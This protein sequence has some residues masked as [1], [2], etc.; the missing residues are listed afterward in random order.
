MS[1]K[2]FI[3]YKFLPV[4]VAFLLNTVACIES[5]PEGTDPVIPEEEMEEQ[6]P[7]GIDVTS[8]LS[9]SNARLVRGTIPEPAML[10]DF[11]IDKDTLYLNANHTDR[12]HLRTS[13]C[14]EEDIASLLIWVV[15]SEEYVTVT[16]ETFIRSSVNDSLFLT[17]RQSRLTE[18]PS[19]PQT[20]LAFEW[21]L[22]CGE[23]Q[24]P[25]YVDI[26]ILPVTTAGV[27]VD[28]IK[29]R[30]MIPDANTV[31][32][33]TPGPDDTWVW[34]WTTVNGEFDSSPGISEIYTFSLNGCCRDGRSVNCLSSFI[35][36]SEWI[37]LDYEHFST[38]D[39]EYLTFKAD[40]TMNGLLS[41]TI[42]NIDPG[43]SDFCDKKPAYRYNA[44]DHLFWGD[45]SFDAST[46]RLRFT[47]IESRETLVDLGSLGVF[48]EYD[49]HFISTGATYELIG[50]N[51]LV[52]ESSVEGMVQRR[53]FERFTRKEAENGTVDFW[54]D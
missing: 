49:R 19:C 46:R 27:P 18:V 38:V 10:L 5:V 23:Q 12:I 51:L 36:E 48:P 31:P 37:S 52:E 40:G 2:L 33:C 34:K 11:K 54:L 45:Y 25:P 30:V 29:R 15:G 26:E 24:L 22:Q 9:I 4:I 17:S 41:L 20:T 35:P 43:S 6:S 44:K 8:C 21:S 3:N 16:P 14:G 28:R 1:K 42:Q 13:D 50:C 47:K 7:P 32:S 39:R 53:Y